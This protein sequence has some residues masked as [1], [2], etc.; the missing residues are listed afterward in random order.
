MTDTHTPKTWLQDAIEG[1]S[2]IAIAKFYA[3]GGVL[4]FLIWVALVVTAGTDQAF[5]GVIIAAAYL[6]ACQYLMA[7][8]WPP[9]VPS[10]EAERAEQLALQTGFS[11]MIVLPKLLTPKD[12]PTLWHGQD[13]ETEGRMVLEVERWDGSK[14]ELHLPMRIVETGVKLIG[15]GPLENQFKQHPVLPTLLRLSISQS[16]HDVGEFAAALASLCFAVLTILGK[17]AEWTLSFATQLAEAG[18]FKLNA[19]A[20]DHFTESCASEKS[21]ENFLQRHLV[22]VERSTS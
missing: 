1:K 21:L 18:G 14:T 9:V 10:P 20:I 3:C 16:Q 8:V 11:A 15:R 4:L 2:V 12:S 17:D 22:I 19:S 6:L 13:G 7:Y 5:L